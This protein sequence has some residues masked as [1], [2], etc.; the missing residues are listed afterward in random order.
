M[1]NGCFLLS[2]QDASL[3]EAHSG[4]EHQC[5]HAAGRKDPAGGQGAFVPSHCGVAMPPLLV[6]LTA[7]AA[8]PGAHAP[9][10][11]K[12][13]RRRIKIGSMLHF[14]LHLGGAPG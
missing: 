3:H 8:E 1:Q 11:R 14:S 5:Q 12:N 2:F 4:R 10:F 9:Y 6:S 7:A 13:L